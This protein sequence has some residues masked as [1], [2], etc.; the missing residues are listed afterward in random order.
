MYSLFLSIE[1]ITIGFLMCPLCF[2]FVYV[3]FPP[4]ECKD[5]HNKCHIGLLREFNEI[6]YMDVLYKLRTQNTV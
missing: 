5:N 1:H 6:M 4:L 2:F 3:Q